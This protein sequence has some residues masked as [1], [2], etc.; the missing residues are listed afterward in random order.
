MGL[1]PPRQALKIARETA[2][3]LQF[4]HE[5]GIIHRDIKPANIMLSPGRDTPKSIV[6]GETLQFSSGASLSYRVLVTDFGLA[7][8][9]SGDSVLTISGTAL[10]TPVYMPPEQADGDLK[11]IG[12]WSD[13]YSLGAVLYE[14]VTGSPLFTGTSLGQI[15]A[16]VLRRDAELAAE[17][18]VSLFG[19]PS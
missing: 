9:M 8:D 6:A 12:P 5:A 4:A 1:V 13:V 3:G 10:G 7:K 2:E 15:L 11:A 19:R 17:T 18:D 16:K 14:M